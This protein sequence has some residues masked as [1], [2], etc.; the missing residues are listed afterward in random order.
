MN[1]VF[2]ELLI[3]FEHRQ[4]SDKLMA[5]VDLQDRL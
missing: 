1:G 4:R 3:V 5:R 2:A